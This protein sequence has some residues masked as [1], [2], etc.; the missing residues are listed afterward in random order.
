MR[1]TEVIIVAMLLLIAFKEGWKTCEHIAVY[2][3]YG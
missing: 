1:H 3:L 2:N